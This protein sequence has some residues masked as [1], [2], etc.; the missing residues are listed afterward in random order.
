MVY[1]EKDSEVL[2]YIYSKEADLEEKTVRLSV[3][4][5]LQ[6]DAVY[7]RAMLETM[8]LSQCK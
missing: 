8:A 2:L 6:W 1:V 4:K 3:D 7:E 5:N